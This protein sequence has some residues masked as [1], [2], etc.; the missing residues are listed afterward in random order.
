MKNQQQHKGNFNLFYPTKWQTRQ[1]ILVFIIII[2]DYN[3]N[4]F[5]CRFELSGV[6]CIIITIIIIIILA[7]ER[8]FW[9]LEADS[10]FFYWNEMFLIR[11]NFS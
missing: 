3:N 10:F 11:I 2:F 4:D 1:S 8:N 7:F 5:P 9:I 6:N